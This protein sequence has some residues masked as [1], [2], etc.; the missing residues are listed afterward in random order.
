MP[1]SDWCLALQSSAIGL[2]GTKIQGEQ[3]SV[4]K[5]IFYKNFPLHVPTPSTT[6]YRVVAVN[7]KQ[8]DKFSLLPLPQKQHAYLPYTR[9]HILC[10]ATYIP[11]NLA[12]VQ[13]IVL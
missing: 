13:H 2:F 11:P 4:K 5:K 3:A 7:T 8:T 10:K 6:R 9:K 12:M 1:W